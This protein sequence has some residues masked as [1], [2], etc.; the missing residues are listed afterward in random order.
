MRNSSSH[1]VI[2]MAF[3]GA[4][5]ITSGRAVCRAGRTEQDVRGSCDRFVEARHLSRYT[6]QAVCEGRDSLLELRTPSEGTACPAS[7][8]R[9]RHQRFHAARATC[10]HHD[11]ISAW[12]QA[13][14]SRHS[15]TRIIASHR[16]RLSSRWPRK[17]LQQ[18]PS[19]R[20]RYGRCERTPQALW[21]RPVR[22]SLTGAPRRPAPSTARPP[23]H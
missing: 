5:S 9:R 20:F 23:R 2:L 3:I 22:P 21:A 19:A 7:R 17:P 16:S 1:H 6:A 18:E 13:S 11:R 4:P 12:L 10:A 15:T 8:H 14:R